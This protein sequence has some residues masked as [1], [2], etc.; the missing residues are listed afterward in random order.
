M[1]VS[2]LDPHPSQYKSVILALPL[3]AL[4][5][6]L[7][8]GLLAVMEKA[9]VVSVLIEALMTL[10]PLLVFA[11]TG[12]LARTMKLPLF[13]S[14][15]KDVPAVL[16]GLTLAAC[17][18]GGSFFPLILSLPYQADYISFPV[19][20]GWGSSLV[21]S[22]VLFAS[23]IR[24]FGSATIPEFLGVRLQSNFVKIIASGLLLLAALPLLATEILVGGQVLASSLS[25]SPTT[26]IML[27]CLTLLATVILGGVSGAVW[28]QALQGVLMVFACLAPVIFLGLDQAT[29]PLVAE[30][31]GFVR[32]VD[33][34]LAEQLKAIVDIENTSI[35][36]FLTASPYAGGLWPL[37]GTAL[38][39][40]VG[41]ASMPHLLG[42]LQTTRSSSDSR[43]ATGYSLSFLLLLIV[44]GSAYFLLLKDER[45]QSLLGPN[46]LGQGSQDG[47]IGALL[48]SGIIAAALAASSALLMAISTSISRDIIETFALPRASLNQK[49]I[50]ARVVVLAVCGLVTYLAFYG[51][52]H[53]LDLLV[54]SISIAASAFFPVLLLSCWWRRFQVTAACGAMLSGSLAAIIYAAAVMSGATGFWFGLPAE[55]G[56]L[57]GVFLAFVVAV[58]LSYIKLFED[59]GSVAMANLLERPV[60]RELTIDTPDG[61]RS[62]DSE[63]AE[64][65]I[66]VRT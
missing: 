29:S 12:I 9:G 54:L 8:T 26:G 63:E 6:F 55:M 56:G 11:I 10:S 44:A 43:R 1:T 2:S 16:A 7:L 62:G 45:L 37:V 19:I 20:L 59:D 40:A 21:L 30:S 22:T 53:F 47:L 27:F 4:A 66:E 3:F 34:S 15:G 41:M 17:F 51:N 42:K 25:A 58:P 64:E 32:A 38:F 23:S 14:G 28:T 49:L 31:A 36:W 24:R 57:L 48:R 18:V 46:A 52:L 50:L 13:H 5:L 60:D 33:T 35:G 61:S 65:L 39:F